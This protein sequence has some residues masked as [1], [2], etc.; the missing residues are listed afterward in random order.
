LKATTPNLTS[1]SPSPLL[2]L[3][4]AEMIYLT[5]ALEFS[6]YE[7]M[8]PVVSRMKTKSIMLEFSLLS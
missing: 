4:A 1:L 3:V 7:D 5:A 8:D 6:M 2:V